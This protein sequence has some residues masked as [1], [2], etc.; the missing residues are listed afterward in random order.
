MNG[1]KWSGY[2]AVRNNLKESESDFCRIYIL[3]QQMRNGY[4]SPSVGYRRKGKGKRS[5][6]EV[7]EIVGRLV[8]L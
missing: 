5:I 3:I 1:S 7:R 2:S 8:G 4:M 6:P